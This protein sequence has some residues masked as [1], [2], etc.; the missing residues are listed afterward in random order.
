MQVRK[1]DHRLTAVAAAVSTDASRYVLNGV[2]VRENGLAEACNG[3][4]LLQSQLAMIEQEELP[5]CIQGEPNTKAVII[6]TDDIKQA[7]KCVPKKCAIDTFKGSAFYV[8]DGLQST[9]ITTTHRTGFKPIDGTFPNADA[10]HPSWRGSSR[11]VFMLTVD[12]L[13]IICNAAKAAKAKRIEFT[14]NDDMTKVSEDA[15]SFVLSNE[16]GPVVSGIVMSCKK[17]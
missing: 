13:K 7:M 9:D 8:G 2:H 10:V 16:D 15:V 12:N 6:P 3:S 11:N 5:P 4:I 14:A 17:E 1:L